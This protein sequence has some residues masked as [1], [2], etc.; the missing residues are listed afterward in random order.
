[1]PDRNILETFIDTVVSGRHDEAIELFYTAEASM[2]ENLDPPRRGRDGLVARER[3]V[4][5]GFK[6]IA[7]SCVRPVFVDGQRSD[8]LGLRV[9]TRRRP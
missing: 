2:Q 5:A 7:T 3:G 4:M 8:S 6:S 1:M 9:R